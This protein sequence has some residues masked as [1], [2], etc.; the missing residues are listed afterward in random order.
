MAS[1]PQQSQHWSKYQ[2]Q[3]VN[4]SPKRKVCYVHAQE[5]AQLIYI[6]LARENNMIFRGAG[7]PF[8]NSI[9]VIVQHACIRVITAT[10]VVWERERETR[11]YGLCP[12]MS[13]TCETVTS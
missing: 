7:R 5:V 11:V 12:H 8:K 1:V 6:R 13:R 4:D 9:S 10:S 2:P 3:H